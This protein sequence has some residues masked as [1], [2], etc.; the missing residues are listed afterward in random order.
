[1]ESQPIAGLCIGFVQ[2]RIKVDSMNHINILWFAAACEC[3]LN[4]VDKIAIH[5][6]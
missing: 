2:A 1:M 6:I 4:S 3:L 5:M